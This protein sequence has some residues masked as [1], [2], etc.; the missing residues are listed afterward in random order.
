[1]P[2]TWTASGRSA[3][4]LIPV[5]V[6]AR[7]GGSPAAAAAGV[8]RPG[9]A[10]RAPRGL[11]LRPRAARVAAE[12]LGPR[13]Q[14]GPPETSSSRGRERCTSSR[15][16]RQGEHGVLRVADYWSAEGLRDPRPRP[17]RPDAVL[18]VARHDGD[19][20]RV[21]TTE[22]GG[23]TRTMTSSGA[24]TPPVLLVAAHR[25][26]GRRST[27]RCVHLPGRRPARP[28]PD[29]SRRR[30]DGSAVAPPPLLATSSTTS[31]DSERCLP[32]SATC[33]AAG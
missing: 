24:T 31:A 25:L 6:P 20:S 22:R 12:G 1:V 28:L 29:H 15:R 11:R 9:G 27:V 2:A 26:R 18:E 23:W 21:S 33:I 5:D 14:P 16:A 19:G 30:A 3:V 10:L 4:E 13:V 7:P 8:V 32:A 17:V